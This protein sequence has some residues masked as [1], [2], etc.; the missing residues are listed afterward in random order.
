VSVQELKKAYEDLAEEDQLLFATL[1]AA[2]Q[3]SRQAGFA[4]DIARRHQAMDA[5]RTWS[6]AD[7]LKLHDELTKQG[8]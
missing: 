4:A 8:L 2:D 5:G 7:V 6:H 1:V 3:L